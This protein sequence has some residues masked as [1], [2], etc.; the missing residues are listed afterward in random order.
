M[1]ERQEGI[2]AV[3]EGYGTVTPWII[4]RNTATL[5][6]F[7]VFT[8]DAT[9]IARVVN[10]DGAIG[11]AEVRIGDSVVM[12]FDS[13]PEW[14]HTGAYLRVYVADADAV[15]GKALEAGAT[16]MTELTVL[17]W[18]DRVGRIRDPL[19][20]VWWIQERLAELSPEAI[21]RRFGEPEFIEAMHYVQSTLAV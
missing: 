10:D 7:V 2:R 18:G 17:A 15:V 4:S 19:G 13:R 1:T 12:M 21:A 9:E 6:E 16:V 14:P 20:N 8:F 3:P 11:H 5:I